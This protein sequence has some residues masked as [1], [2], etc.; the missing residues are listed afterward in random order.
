MRHFLFKTPEGLERRAGKLGAP[1]VALEHDPERVKALLGRKQRVGDHTVGN[2][3][4]IHPMEGCD[5]NPDGR[6]G[7]FTRRRYERFAQGGAKLIWI[8]S[9]AVS[10]E[11][12]SN[13]RQLWLCPETMPDFAKLLETVRR[14]HRRAFGR[15]GDLLE[16]L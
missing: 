2:S 8:E 5:A 7:E 12:R 16:V 13:P 14:S 4:A 11:A 9:T 10:G 6:P 3:I 1:D 15:A